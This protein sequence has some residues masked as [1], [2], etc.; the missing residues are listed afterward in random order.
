MK[1]VSSDEL[2]SKL[3]ECLG[4][5]KQT[6]EFS[7][8]CVAGKPVTV[9]CE[10]YPDVDADRLGTVLAGYKVVRRDEQATRNVEMPAAIRVEIEPRSLAVIRF[11][12][13]RLRTYTNR[14]KARLMGHPFPD[15]YDWAKRK[16]VAA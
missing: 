7:L 15:L 10:Y 16:A 2:G 8:R 13:E 9:Q 6:R 5:P 11:F 14:D 12:A 1:K 3:I 4:L